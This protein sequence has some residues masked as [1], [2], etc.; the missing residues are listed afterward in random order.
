MPQSLDRR[1][2]IE[3]RFGRTTPEEV[4]QR[5]R[6][7]AEFE[8][9]VVSVLDDVVQNEVRCYPRPALVVNDHNGSITQSPLAPVD[10][11]G[12]GARAFSADS[13]RINTAY[14]PYARVLQGA[15]QNPNIPRIHPTDGKVVIR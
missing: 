9:R 4:H 12:Y 15:L 1:T 2:R 8:T 10:D 7:V 11:A 5:L 3:N 13:A 14:H 6:R